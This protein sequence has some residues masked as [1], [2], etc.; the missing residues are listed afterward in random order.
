[1]KKYNAKEIERDDFYLEHKKYL[2]QF[3]IEEYRPELLKELPKPEYPK[4]ADKD[5]WREFHA[6]YEEWAEGVNE[7]FR[8][9]F[10]NGFPRI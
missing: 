10:S 4:E 9:G 2:K 7:H 5:Q 1:M 8:E 6:K 3:L